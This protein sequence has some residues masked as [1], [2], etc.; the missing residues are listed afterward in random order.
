MSSDYDNEET[1]DGEFNEKDIVFKDDQVYDTELEDFVI[2]NV[3]GIY[4]Y[5]Y[6]FLKWE[7]INDLS[8]QNFAQYRSIISK[9][10]TESNEL[11]CKLKKKMDK[12]EKDTKFLIEILVKKENNDIIKILHTQNN[13]NFLLEKICVGCY[14]QV[15]NKVKCF[16]NDTCPGLCEDCQLISDQSICNACNKSQT[17]MCP[18]CYV[19]KP[20]D[21]MCKS[22]NC[23]HSVCWE[24]IGRSCRAGNTIDLCPLCRAPLD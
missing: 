5:K 6:G 2:K 22:N 23:S 11:K 18:T 21:K 16:Y 14:K 19:D 13:S 24:C 17:I 4:I 9:F 7:Q 1:S 20:S 12:I 15:D 8:S 10:M 3:P